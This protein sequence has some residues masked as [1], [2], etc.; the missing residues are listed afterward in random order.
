MNAAASVRTLNRKMGWTLPTT[1]PRTLNG[2]IIEYLETIP[3]P[4]TSL[5]IDDYALD[6]LQTGDNAV[7]TVRLGDPRR[8]RATRSQNAGPGRLRAAQRRTA[9][10]AS[11]RAQ[12]VLQR[13]RLHSRPRSPARHVRR[14]HHRAPEALL[15]RLAQPLLAERHRTDLAGESELAEADRVPRRAA[16]RAGSTATASTAGRSAAVSPMRTPPTTLTNTSRPGRRRSPPCR[17]STASS[18]ARRLASNPTATRR[19]IMPCASS[20]SACT[21]TSSG[22]LP[23]R[24]T[25]T[26][27]PGTGVRV[28][29]Q[30][31][32]RRIAHFLQPLLGHREHADLV[33]GAEAVLHG[34]YHAD[35]DCPGRSR[36][37]ARCPPCARGCA[38]P[39]SVLPW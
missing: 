30:E 36:S 39:R 3:D 2:L 8:R 22:R 5:R 34:T 16:G 29:R 32:R 11:E 4:G 27:L 1:G 25:V 28:T 35:S 7:K 37:R 15:G 38:D 24:A 21:S 26:T 17:C 33:G 13:P 9:T 18:S 31:D 6:I 14:R 12:R 20:M 10:A 19:G 23:S